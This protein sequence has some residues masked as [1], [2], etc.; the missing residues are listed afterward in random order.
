MFGLAQWCCHTVP[1]PLGMALG[2]LSSENPL[3]TRTLLQ[4][5]PSSIL[6][7][8]KSDMSV[9]PHNSVKMCAINNPLQALF[10]ILSLFGFGLCAA[11][12]A[13][14]SDLV[15]PVSVKTNN[16]WLPV[17][18]DGPKFNVSVVGSYNIS[19]RYCTPQE[20]VHSRLETLQILVH[21][22]SYDKTCKNNLSASAAT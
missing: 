10:L 6:P 17:G 18:E 22:A 14:C 1:P 3:K 5:H 7:D 21:G 19:A 11:L 20:D 15:I 4:H 13:G 16:L 9:D 8:S 12:Q 2:G